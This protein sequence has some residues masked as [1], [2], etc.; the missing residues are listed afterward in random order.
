MH[1]A[2]V[3]LS[4]HFSGYN[5]Y[6]TQYKERYEMQNIS[7]TV[8]YDNKPYKQGLETG[9]GFSALITSAEKTILF[10]SGRDRSLL[11]NMEKLAIEPGGIDIVILSHIHPDHSGGL[12][13]FLEENP[14][15]TVYLPKSFPRQFKDNVQGHGTKMVEVEQP[16]K[17]CED[18]YSAGQ[19]GKWIR[20]QSLLIQTDKGLI[21]IIGCAHPGIVNIVNATKGL[22]KDD[23]LFVMGGFHLEWASRGKIKKIISAFKKLNV[24]YVGLCHCSGD[25][26]RD[27]LQSDNSGRFTIKLVWSLRRPDAF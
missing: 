19:P 6:R 25:K 3:L 7:I 20:E 22:I 15:V 9:W 8:V 10:D 1:F 27:L 26:A 21:L 18:V 17:I 13:G 24:R 2:D 4:R 11:N 23:F 5:C 16:M 14:N 12:V